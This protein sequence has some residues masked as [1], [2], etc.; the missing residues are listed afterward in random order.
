MLTLY[1]GNE[2]YPMLFFVFDRI[3]SEGAAFKKTFLLHS[4]NEPTV[5]NTS[6]SA[7]VTDGEGKLVMHSVSGADSIEKIGGEG[8]AYWINGKNCLDQYTTSDN[9]NVIWG[10][11]EITATGNL[12]DSFLTA[13]YVTDAD[14]ENYLTVEGG[15]TDSV[16][17]VKMLDNI[18]VFADAEMRLR[19]GFSIG[20]EGEGLY[21]YYV[22]GLS[23][24]EWQIK[25]GEKSTTVKISAD[26]RFASFTASAGNITIA[27]A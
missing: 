4:V 22:S 1:T 26:E 27:K 11:I 25:V 12:T 18:V 15:E 20:I 13:M 9:A 10:R 8:Y 14:N 24:G 6:M 17:F 23:E 2:D 16:K 21:T 3:T 7:V 19:R 5:D